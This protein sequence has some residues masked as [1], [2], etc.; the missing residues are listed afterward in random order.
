MWRSVMTILLMCVAVTLLGYLIH[1]VLLG[2]DYQAVSHLHRPMPQFGAL[3]FAN[4][5]F[6][7]AAV[8]L[9]HEVPFGATIARSALKL[10]L[11]LWMIWAV[12]MFVIE[13]AL[14][15]IAL[16]LTLKQLAFELADM[17][18]IGFMLTMAVRTSPRVP[19]S[20]LRG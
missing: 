16:S 18:V 12:P 17:L 8:W 1:G 3:L 11:L 13:F 20:G 7:A 19:Q 5:A 4:L 15:P 9:R 10:G 14:Q 6:S 2:A